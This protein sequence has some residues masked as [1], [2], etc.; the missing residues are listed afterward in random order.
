MISAFSTEPDPFDNGPIVPGRSGHL[1][2]PS[3][4]D[5]HVHTQYSYDCAMPLEAILEQA[6]RAGLT[7]LCVTDHD[8]IEGALAMEQLRPADLEIVVGCE[9]TADDGS[10]VIGLGL[11]EMIASKP[12]LD[13]I[14]AIKQQGGLVLLPHPFRRSSGIFRNEMQRSKAFIGDV[15]AFSDLVEC[16]NGGDSYVNNNRNYQLAAEHG[17]SAVAGSDAHALFA[18]GSVFVEYAE[19]DR[20]HGVSHRRIFAPPQRP[21]VENPLKRMLMETYHRHKAS[22]PAVM[23]EAYRIAKRRLGP[24]V[25]VTGKPVPRLQYEFGPSHPRSDG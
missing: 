7:C 1:V 23:R 12:V 2:Q 20:V 4:V 6:T 19:G 15:F 17:L 14:E 8:T 16:F 24:D 5:Y 10:H 21:M 11:K 25:P 13:L 22:L 3:R 18:I 9:F